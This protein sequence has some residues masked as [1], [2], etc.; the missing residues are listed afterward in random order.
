M[1]KLLIKIEENELDTIK[2]LSGYGQMEEISALL[3]LFSIE[4]ES[5][6]IKKIEKLKGVI[7]IEQE[8]EGRLLYV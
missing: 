5:L 6:P 1:E 3:N 4:G 8:K 7:S 2:K